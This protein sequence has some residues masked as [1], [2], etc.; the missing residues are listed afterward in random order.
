MTVSI[1][2]YIYIYIYL[3]SFKRYIP[4]RI[5]LFASIN[6]TCTSKLLV[7]RNVCD[8]CELSLFS[9]MLM[10]NYFSYFA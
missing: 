5:C 10:S 9:Q 6:G 7:Y 1:Y 2:I 8:F 4:K 3:I